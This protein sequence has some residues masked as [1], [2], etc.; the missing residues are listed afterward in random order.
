MSMLSAI[1]LLRKPHSGRSH[2]I[3]I[4]LERR[5]IENLFDIDVG[6]A[7]GISRI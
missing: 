2:S 5:V 6:P 4:E 7:P 1:S 3:D